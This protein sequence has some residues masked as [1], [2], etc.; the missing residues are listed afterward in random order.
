MFEINPAIFILLCEAVGVLSIV[1]TWLIVVKIKKQSQMQKAA[2]ALVSQIH[3]Q[4][5][6][7]TEQTGSFLQE[8]YQLEDAELA[9]A[10]KTIDQ[11]EKK[12]FQVIIDAFA[13]NETDRIKSIDADLAELIDTYKTLKPK[14]EKLDISDSEATL[15]ELERL[16]KENASL[17]EELAITNKTMADMI[18][19]YG[20]MF[21]GGS[22]HE[23]EQ[24]D[25]VEKVIKED[26]DQDDSKVSDV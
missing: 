25:I 23:L 20:N 2:G 16:V 4:S 18:G 26:S 21:G 13:K 24:G 10:V 14:K 8:I 15:A 5:K 6:T 9:K 22:D 17:R 3:Q 19:E 1:C 7:R 12:F 11:H